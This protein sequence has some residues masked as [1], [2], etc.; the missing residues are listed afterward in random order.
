MTIDFFHSPKIND[1]EFITE[2]LH[3]KTME[4]FPH[5]C[6]SDGFLLSAAI[7]LPNRVLLDSDTCEK[8]QMTPLEFLH[9]KIK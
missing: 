9:G 7:N 8:S 1:G 5:D 4:N 3:V 6:D 2:D